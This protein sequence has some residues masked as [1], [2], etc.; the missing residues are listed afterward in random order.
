MNRSLTRKVKRREEYPVWI[1]VQPT[2]EQYDF[3]L[4]ALM[5]EETIRAKHPHRP[6]SSAGVRRQPFL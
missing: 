4:Q 1:H 5:K 2:V 6:I 3:K